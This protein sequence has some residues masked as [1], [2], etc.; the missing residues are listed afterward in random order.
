MI[1]DYFLLGLRNI[2]GRKLR[3]YLTIVGII[4][5]IASI[6]ALISISQ[7]L[8]NAI[9]E[10]FDKMGVKDI[11]VMPKGMRGPPVGSDALTTKDVDT[12]ENIVGV[13]YVT[14]VLLS[15]VNV[16]FNNKK[17]FTSVI[18][19]STDNIERSFADVDLG[20]SEG[21]N[22][23]KG[24]KG[25]MLVG[26]NTAHDSFDK[27]IRLRNTVKVEDM[28]F[29]VVGIF[30]KQGNPQLDNSIYIPME[31]GRDIFEKPDEVSVIVVHLQ[32]GYDIDKMTDKI[33]TKLKRAR[34]NENFQVITPKE[35]LNQLNTILGIVEI[36]LVGIAAISL[37]VGGVGIMNAMYTSVL[38]RTREIGV[39]KA[40]GARNSSILIIFLIESGM[41]GLV[42]GV[43]GAALGTLFALSFGGIAAQMG[44]SLLS[45]KVEWGLILFVL[46]F[47]FIVGVV[48][49]TLPAVRASK[50][51]PAEALR[52]E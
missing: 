41:I 36:I 20:F 23:K 8:E 51:R 16:E 24:E 17:T 5:G 45:I 52:Y 34:D 47:A 38:E 18:A 27:D 3:A 35:L 15:Y 50:M 44:F 19:Y 21:R 26:Y 13:D 32:E 31:Q 2:R 37:L 49:G 10:Q 11:R 14:P 48:S 40:I 30:E 28:E 6:V 4:I 43:V 46:G 22:L 33:Y 42:G 29:K 1:D 12:V 7:G 25:S 9:T 39:M